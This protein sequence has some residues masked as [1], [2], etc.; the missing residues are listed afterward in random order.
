MFGIDHAQ[1]ENLKDSAGNPVSIENSYMVYNVFI[2]F[3]SMFVFG[4]KSPIGKG[5]QDLHKVGDKI[6]HSAAYSVAPTNLG[7]QIKEGSVFR[8]GEITLEFKGLGVVNKKTCALLGYDSG[9]SSFTMLMQYSPTMEVNTNGSS[10]YWG[11]IYKDLP[12]GWLQLATLHEFVV[13]ETVFGTNRIHGVIE[14]NISIK[15]IEGSR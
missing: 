11:D 8:N 10:H 2:D 7:K 1:F 12:S 3:H 13:S 9:A 4:E 14:R 15:N 6:I 5:V